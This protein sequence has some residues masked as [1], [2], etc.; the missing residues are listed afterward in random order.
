MSNKR[1]ILVVRLLVGVFNLAAAFING[2]PLTTQAPCSLAA[3][4]LSRSANRG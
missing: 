1:T 4:F 3:G 2:D